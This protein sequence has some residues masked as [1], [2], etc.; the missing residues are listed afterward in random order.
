MAGWK[1]YLNVGCGGRFHADWCNVDMCPRDPSVLRHDAR[2]PLPFPG[3]SFEAV[4]HS[5]LLE[6]LPRSKALAFLCEC[7]RVLKPGG[8]VRV[9]VPDLEQIARLYLHA[10]DAAASGDSAAQADHGW[11]MLE[12]YD[13][14]VRTESGGDMLRH[15][16]DEKLPNRSF[17]LERLGREAAQ[18]LAGSPRP[19]PSGGRRSLFSKSGKVR[20][21]WREIRGALRSPRDWLLRRLL[22]R[23]FEAL[24][25]GR[26]RLAGEVH[27]WMYDRYALTALLEEAGFVA[28]RVVAPAES[29]I[30]D[31]VA[32]GLDFEPDLTASKPDSLFMEALKPRAAAQEAARRR[33]DWTGLPQSDTLTA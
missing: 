29:L 30:P 4:Y 1:P 22:G 15:I 28:P 6:H 24:Q 3:E 8:I 9:V 23:D 10:L 21:V 17:V 26:F 16:V 20:T 27:Q 2:Q 19:Q 33:Q 11:L 25:V 7:H 31:W 14:V 32:Y 5:H 18:I 13:Q 12:L